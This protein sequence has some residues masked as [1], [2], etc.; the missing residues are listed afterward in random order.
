MSFNVSVLIG[1]SHVLIGF[2]A[3]DDDPI[4]DLLDN[5][6]LPVVAISDFRIRL[7]YARLAVCQQM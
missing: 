5:L 6:A 3:E 4:L 7:R 2:R 1:V